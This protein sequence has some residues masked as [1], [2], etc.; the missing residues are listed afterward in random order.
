MRRLLKITSVILIQAFLVMDFAW[1]GDIFSSVRNLTE[2]DTLAPKVA[3]DIKSF[4]DGF[5]EF[6][7]ANQQDMDAGSDVKSTALKNPDANKN[8]SGIVGAG[9]K[10]IVAA[11]LFLMFMLPLKSD[12]LGVNP[13]AMAQSPPAPQVEQVLDELK[14]IVRNDYPYIADTIEKLDEAG[15]E[16]RVDDT[17]EER[18]PMGATNMSPEKFLLPEVFGKPFVSYSPAV[19]QNQVDLFKQEYPGLFAQ[20]P[21]LEKILGHALELAV[22]GH[23]ITHSQEGNILEAHNR[24]SKAWRA[25]LNEYVSVFSEGEDIVSLK[26]EDDSNKTFRYILEKMDV[27][28]AIIN[29][30]DEN[31]NSLKYMGRYVEWEINNRLIVIGKSLWALGVLGFAGYFGLRFMRGVSKSISRS[32]SLNTYRR[33]STRR[34]QHLTHNYGGNRYVRVGN[35]SFLRKLWNTL[36]RQGKPW[37]RF[38]T[39]LFFP[40]SVS[41]ADGM[42]VF[43]LFS[44]TV[45][46]FVITAVAMAAVVWF[47][48]QIMKPFEKETTADVMLSAEEPEKEESSEVSAEFLA[49]EGFEKGRLDSVIFIDVDLMRLT[50]DYISKPNVNV[51]LESLVKE[52]EALRK[53]LRSDNAV[54]FRRGGDEFVLA[55]N[56]ELGKTASDLAKRI[57]EKIENTVFAVGSLGREPIDEHVINS[58]ERNGGKVS[59]VGRQAILIVQKNEGKTA[60]QSLTDFINMTNVHNQS[61]K[62]RL[63]ESWLDRKA[64][65][66]Q[67]S[68]TLSIGVAGASDVTEVNYDAVHDLAAFRKDKSKEGFKISGNGPVN[69]SAPLEKTHE[70]GESIIPEKASD[71]QLEVEMFKEMEQAANKQEEEGIDTG[72]QPIWDMS[73]RYFSRQSIARKAVQ[74]MQHNNPE[75]FANAIAFSMQMFGYADEAGKIKGYV[76]DYY[77]FPTAIK[78]NRI[79][80]RDFKVVNDALG[81]RA[82]DEV[83]AR[84]RIAAI[85]FADLLEYYDVIFVRGPPAGPTGFLVPKFEAATG[86]TAAR[87]NEMFKKYITAVESEFNRN[88]KVKAEHLRIIW[89]MF[90]T[91]ER[92]IGRIMDDIYKTRV[93]NEHML[94]Y[95]AGICEVIQCDAV[96]IESQGAELE[97]VLANE[98][99]ESLEALQQVWKLGN[100]TVHNHLK[101]QP[102]IQDLLVPRSSVLE[103]IPLREIINHSV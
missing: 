88:N 58:I 17:L 67:V 54:W 99:V 43:E 98:A 37:N 102:V 72:I 2:P 69:N 80:T 53:D 71:L 6:T 15:V 94:G 13:A 29:R 42:T 40:A 41:A 24:L 63:H 46:F 31:R 47:V 100:V 78:D 55:V 8:G 49:R 70:E 35:V 73:V 10:I 1:A 38:F 39:N 50:N 11:A 45:K 4:Q 60:C 3:I 27:P 81:Y 44:E 33:Q 25:H 9:K 95:E 16:V 75:L 32:G 84:S 36:T 28:T 34:V 92:D 85:K 48:W 68:F 74:R 77:R 65:N 23:E 14:Q 103:K 76:E 86:L 91:A 89:D 59:Y 79:D 22:L 52:L 20:N 93:V 26:I 101:N 7:K 18:N 82:G 61:Q 87:I 83:I 21:N 56:S 97:E 64:I 90:G 51:L 5:S 30:I 66:N 12:L 57:K 19:I 62:L 96:S